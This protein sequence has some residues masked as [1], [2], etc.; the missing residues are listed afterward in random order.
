MNSKMFAK[1]SICPKFRPDVAIR[2][3][4]KETLLGFGPIALL[5]IFPGLWLAACLA[6]P[7]PGPTVTHVVLMWLKHP[8]RA[9][10]RAQL[11]RAAQSL[12]MIPGVLRVE[13]GRTI[14][15]LGPEVRR[16]FDLGVVITFRDRAALQRYQRDPGHLEAMRRYLDPLVRH[17]EVY[18][19]NGR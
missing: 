10:D 9:G 18:N 12:R 3:A 13:T 14:S 8:H 17:Y 2:F 6:P 5:L 15:P 11:V 19:L 16:D 4:K 1:R 7:P